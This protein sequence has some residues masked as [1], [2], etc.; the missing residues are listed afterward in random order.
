MIL[1]KDILK[2]L[3]SAKDRFHNIF[4][5]NFKFKVHKKFAIFCF[6]WSYTSS[7]QSLLILHTCNWCLIKKKKNFQVIKNNTLALFFQMDVTGKKW[8][9]RIGLIPW[10]LYLN[11]LLWSDN[12]FWTIKCMYSQLV[13]GFQIF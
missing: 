7:Y 11:E 1:K 13:K 4:S 12:D 2:R 8:R 3:E 6:F 10:N 9:K 5:S